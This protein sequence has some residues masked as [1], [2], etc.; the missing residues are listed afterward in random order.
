[1]EALQLLHRVPN[2][3]VTERAKTYQ[4]A[5]ELSA[6]LG[7]TDLV[8]SYYQKAKMLFEQ[9]LGSEHREVANTLANWGAFYALHGN[10]E[11]AERLLRQTLEIRQHTLGRDHPE[12]ADGLV[13][14]AAIL[15]QKAHY[16]EAEEC[17][18]QALTIRQQK[19]GLYHPDILQ[20]LRSL[21]QL[22]AAQKKDEIAERYFREAL[23]LAP[24]DRETASSEYALLLKAYAK[25]LQ[26][27]GRMDEADKVRKE[28]Y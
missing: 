3:N 16:N 25:Y 1:M 5:A 28:E 24:S 12:T 26:E 14:L 27:R 11:E 6:L 20:T 9:T 7:K 8:E 22:A 2:P 19:L 4:I 13:T 10:L 18:Q 17:Y 21:A 15:W 23:A